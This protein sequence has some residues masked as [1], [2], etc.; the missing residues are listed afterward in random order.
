MKDHLAG[1]LLLLVFL[2]LPTT[3][4][5]SDTKYSE[6]R[7]PVGSQRD[8]RMLQEKGL[9]FDHVKYHEGYIDVVLNERDISILRS[10]G[11]GYEILIDDL[12]SDFL[13]RSTITPQA[14]QELQDRMKTEYPLAGFEF[15]SMGGFYTFDEVVRE[16]DSMRLVY[17]TLI[18]EKALIG[19]SI[20]GRDI[21]MVKISDNPE[22]SEQEPD[23]LYT[24]LHHAREPQGLMTVMYFMYYLLENY[25]TD[26]EVTDLIN[27]R[28]L[29][30]VPVVN[31]DGYVHNEET[32]PNG[33]GMWR[34]NR[35]VNEGG[36]YGVDLNRNYGYYWGYD[37]FGSSPDP[38]SETYRGTGPFSEPETQIIR[39]FCDA[40]EV[41]LCLNYHTYGNLL[42]YPWAYLDTPTPDSII[43]TALAVDM[44]QYN[45]YVYGT[46]GETVGYTVNGSSDDWMYGEQTTKPKIF[47]MTPE[48]G[49][50]FWPSPSEI[51]P[52]AQENVY[53]NLQLAHGAGV[54][55]A[56]AYDPNPP[57]GVLAYS[58][59]LTPTSALLT[60]SDP[61]TYVGGD[62]LVDFS[63]EIYRDGGLIGTIAPGLE[64]FTDVGLTD[65][66]S[67]A[68]ELFARDTNDS[69]SA[70]A[71]TSVFAGGARQPSPPSTLVIFHEE[72][73]ILLRWTNPAENI[74]GTPMDDFAGI[75]LYEDGLLIGSFA[76]ASADTGRV[77][78]V[79]HVPAP[80]PHE[81]Y[82]TAFDNETPVN[83]SAPSNI[84]SPPLRLPF[85]DSFPALPLPSSAYWLNLYGEV[86][87]L[88]DNPPS[89][90]YVLT[91]DG[92]PVGGDT[93]ALLPVNLIGL[94][95]QGV[96]LTYAYQPKGLGN[97]PEADDSLY[98][99]FLND[100]GD[101]ID[102]ASYPGS[103]LFAF[104]TEAIDIRS[105]DPGAGATFF[106]A[107]FQL[108]FRNLGSPHPTFHN[109]NW[110]VDDVR[111]EVVTAAAEGENTLPTGFAVSPSYPNPFNPS[112]TIRYE[113]PEVAR[114]RL[115][116]FDILGRKIRT[117]VDEQ[118]EGG[119]YQ[120]VWDARNDA[121]LSVGSGVYVFR[122]EAGDFS[123]SGKMLLV[124]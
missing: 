92:H 97:A 119:R 86:T 100:L 33:G 87:A 101:W 18:T 65:G 107:E 96:I 64:T 105:V 52:L 93:V 114:A 109:D 111:L 24:A 16:L 108:R 54:I 31:P 112:T 110:H 47:A 14:W 49:D 84:T 8:V 85:S 118:Q 6:V 27:T 57:T 78:S 122:F 42:I 37:D 20:E 53:P 39:D 73:G 34:K 13:A 61:T 40:R 50:W 32:N 66:E 23:I 4:Q 103:G 113:L 17:P 89:P 63:I 10:E 82:V 115:L 46:P 12:Q 38:W 41:M 102:A 79:E 43:F 3:G 28:E 120:A 21:W 106:H 99:E 30:F 74:D 55:T 59:Y 121:G 72:S 25:G 15:G 104:R 75:N 91:L 76:R 68:Y 67:Y 29:Y 11:I 94:S 60:W 5:S 95:G 116:V 69:L 62:T 88:G 80:G 70:A 9:E 98:V 117:L 83:E 81:Y 71:I 2:L 48:V 123:A 1:Y 44:T 35:R 7:I 45:G 51:Y 26:P 36:S 58:D 90:P 19:L 77:D 124:R 22:V 56:E